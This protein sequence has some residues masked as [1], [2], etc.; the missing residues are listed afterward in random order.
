VVLG[1]IG[2]TG[3]YAIGG[4]SDV[5]VKEVETPFG[6]PS[7]P[8]TVG[9][10]GPCKLLF[11]PRHGNHHQIGPS[12]INYRANIWALKHLGAQAVIS[13]SAVG[14]LQ[15]AIA[16]GDVIVPDQL[17]DRTTE[18]ERSFFTDGIVGHVMFAEPYCTDLR[19][20]ICESVKAVTNRLHSTA[21]L[22]CME[23]PQFSTRAESH[24]HR[25]LG[26]SIVGMTALPEAKLAREAEMC[27][28]NLC[29]CTDYDCWKDD[30]DDVSVDGVMA[31]LHANVERSKAILRQI[32]QRLPF[33]CSCGCETA[34]EYAIITPISQ[35]PEHVKQ[36][37]ALFYG[38]Y[39][40]KQ[41]STP[42]G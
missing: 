4:L 35:V 18:R 2:G 16:P 27:Y 30:G 11:L 34:A 24:M 28:A 26:A 17:I 8:L 31:V 5:V 39:F 38:K 22:V 25:Q 21:T 15:E 6:A 3:L 14:S 42:D 19:R 29:M 1:I 36:R 32:C 12:Q 41:Q 10:L 20:I 23:G 9:H 7:A 13:V 37:L 40:D 33:R